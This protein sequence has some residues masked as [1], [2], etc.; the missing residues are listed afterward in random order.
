[1]Q[2]IVSSNVARAGYDAERQVLTVEFRSGGIYEYSS[3]AQ[4]LFDQLTNGQP[5]PW[6]RVG[7]VIKQHPNHRI[8]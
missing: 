6:T 4:S 3:V 8:G 1:M 5:H 7:P 2:S